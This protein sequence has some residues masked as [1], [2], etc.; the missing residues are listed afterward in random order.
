MVRVGGGERD[1]HR[2]GDGRVPFKRRDTVYLREQL[3]ERRLS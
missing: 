1:T 3:L 2:Y